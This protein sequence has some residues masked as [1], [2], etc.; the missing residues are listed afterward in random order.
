[1]TKISIKGR[2]AKVIEPVLDFFLDTLVPYN[3][4][5]RTKLKNITFPKSIPAHYILNQKIQRLQ[6][7]AFLRDHKGIQKPRIVKAWW[8]RGLYNFGDELLPYLIANICGI[9]CIYSAQKELISIGSTIRFAEQHTYVWGSGIIRK[10][11]TIKTKPVCLAVRGPITKEHLNQQN[12]DCPAVFGDPAMLFPLF[13]NAKTLKNN[14]ERPLIIPHFKHTHLVK[15]NEKYDYANIQINSIYD[16]EHLINQIRTAPTVITSSLHVF[17]FC[18]AYGIPVSVFTMEQQGIGGDNI[19]FDD[20]CDGV[21]AEHVTI[22]KIKNKLDTNETKEL[23]SQ[24][25]I[26]EHKWSPLPLLKSL[27]T[28]YDTP[29]LQNLIRDISDND[30]LRE[31]V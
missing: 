24:A 22:H 11:E 27:Q 12:I 29:T 14:A 31:A 7:Q 2:I 28:V 4:L 9:N 17:I 13:F 30:A 1:M 19:K 10:N 15:H 20:F 23:I 21:N 8:S 3:L 25:K 16:I 26:Y 18:V 5:S 6:I